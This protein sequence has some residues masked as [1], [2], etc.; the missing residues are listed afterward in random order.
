VDH[1]AKALPA[2]PLSE[3]D[4]MVSLLA[5]NIPPLPGLQLTDDFHGAKLAISHQQDRY[6]WRDQ[7]PQIGQQSQLFGGGAMSFGAPDPGPGDGNSP[8]AVGNG[9]DQKLVVETDPSGLSPLGRSLG[10]IGDQADFAYRGGHGLKGSSGNGFIPFSHPHRW[11]GQE[12]AQASGDAEQLGWAWDLVGDLG[13]VNR[14]ALVDTYDQPSE[15]PQPG[16]SLMRSQ[17]LNPLKPGMIQL[18]GRHWSPLWKV[19][20]V[21]QNNFTGFDP[22]DQTFVVKVSGS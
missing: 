14:S 22:V 16:E 2:T 15:G 13:Q 10:A 11:V 21:L 6:T 17:L 9:D 20:S 5:Q 12:T 4:L 8:A 1:S 18:V 3:F 19:V 7:L